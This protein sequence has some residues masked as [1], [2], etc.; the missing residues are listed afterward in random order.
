MLK[1]AK[2]HKVNIMKGANLKPMR[3]H[4]SRAKFLEEEEGAVVDGMII[5]HNHG[6]KG[7]RI[8][9]EKKVE[10]VKQQMARPMNI[11]EDVEWDMEEYAAIDREEKEV[12]EGN[13]EEQVREPEAQE[14]VAVVVVV[15]EVEDT[16]SNT[17]SRTMTTG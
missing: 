1:M 14:G 9:K 5:N 17:N 3:K 6:G 13:S 2:A 16:V 4:T 12:A 8:L 11:E 10:M 7:S 15:V